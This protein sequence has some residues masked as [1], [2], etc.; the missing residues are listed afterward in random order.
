VIRIV[1][2]PPTSESATTAKESHLL[3]DERQR[4]PTTGRYATM[5]R[6]PFPSV[7][8]R[9]QSLGVGLAKLRDQRGGR[10]VRE[11]E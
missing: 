10:L 3:S 4:F 1:V 7:F 6:L 8:E 11:D 9:D 2:M 5:N